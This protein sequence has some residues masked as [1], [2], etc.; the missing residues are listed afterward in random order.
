MYQIGY[1][2]L[3][4]LTCLVQ[5]ENEHIQFKQISSKTPYM[6]SIY[7]CTVEIQFRFI[8]SCW[9]LSRFRIPTDIMHR[10]IYIHFSMQVSRIDDKS[11]IK[12]PLQNRYLCFE[13]HIATNTRSFIWTFRLD[14]GVE[15][16]RYTSLKSLNYDI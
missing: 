5:N 6:Y 3:F 10:V 8:A 9:K 1:I 14:T 7:K 13:N 12:T 16:R 4:K 2:F 11:V 15:K